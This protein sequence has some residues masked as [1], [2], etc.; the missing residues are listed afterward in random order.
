MNC[1]NVLC[2]VA[3][4][5]LLTTVHPLLSLLDFTFGVLEKYLSVGNITLVYCPLFQETFQSDFVCQ[6]IETIN[7]MNALLRFLI[8]LRQ[9]WQQICHP[10]WMGR[11]LEDIVLLVLS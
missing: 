6:Q 10:F 9:Y 11:D 1:W 7:I 3:D 4:G 5:N 8:D 2:L